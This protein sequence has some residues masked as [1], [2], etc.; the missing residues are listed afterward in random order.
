MRERA[1]LEQELGALF[2]GFVE[3]RQYE[4]YPIWRKQ[5]DWYEAKLYVPYQEYDEKESIIVH[6]LRFKGTSDEV[7]LVFAGVH[8]SEPQGVEAANK[9]VE[10]LKNAARSGKK[11]KFTTIVIPELIGKG[12]RMMNPP[13]SD[14]LRY[15]HLFICGKLIEPNRNFPGPGE[16]YKDAL[17]RGHNRSDRAELIDSKDKPLTGD[18]VTH[19]MLAETRILVQLIEREKP[20]R[21]ASIHAHSVPGERGDGAGIFVDPRGGFNTISDRAK[22]TEGIDDDNLTTEML[23]EAQNLIS[24]KLS[25]KDDNG[26]KLHNPFFGNLADSKGRLPGKPS[27]TVHYTSKKHPPGTSFGM[28]APAPDKTGIRKGITTVTVEIPRYKNATTALKEVIDA[29]VQVLLEK[30]LGLPP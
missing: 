26:N 4:F 29:H 1:A 16:S 19:R 11:P 8:G 2:A 6:A 12:R 17:T 13:S 15:V 27:P 24:S 20:V 28:W 23:K 21:A 3:E 10:K 30:F 5:D 22:T 14:Y 7:A 25:L 18:K 9:L